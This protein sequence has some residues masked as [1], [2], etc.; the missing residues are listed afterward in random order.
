M[1]KL[2]DKQ[3]LNNFLYKQLPISKDEFS[4]TLEH[5]L[6]KAAKDFFQKIIYVFLCFV[7]FWY[8]LKYT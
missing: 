6:Q 8:M 3:K 2:L 1:K 7:L 4:T 5:N